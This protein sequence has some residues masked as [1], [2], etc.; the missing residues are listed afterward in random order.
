MPHIIKKRVRDLRRRQAEAEE[1]LWG[2]LRN[3]RCSGEK[4]VRQYPLSYAVNGD[5]RFFVADFYCHRKRL[6]IEADGG[7]HA[8]RK[9]C[10]ACRDEI[11]HMKELTILRLTN[12]EVFSDINQVMQTICGALNR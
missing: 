9:N 6:V 5:R 3:R 7:I 1:I 10:D 2:Y 8:G 4:F 12:D 11:L